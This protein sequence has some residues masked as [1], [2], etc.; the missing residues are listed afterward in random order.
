MYF[1]W[2]KLLSLAYIKNMTKQYGSLSMV[3]DIFTASHKNRCSS[4][5]RPIKP[6]IADLKPVWKIPGTTEKVQ[7]VKMAAV[8]V[9][10]C[11][12]NKEPSL[13]LTVRSSQLLGYKGEVRYIITELCFISAQI[14][15]QFTPIKRLLP[16]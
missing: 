7:N 3:D 8:L 4:R 1:S 10:L 12:V 9:P 15:H 14:V 5:L 11:F 13:L 16:L 2:M 6:G